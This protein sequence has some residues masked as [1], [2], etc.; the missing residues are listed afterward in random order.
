MD[1][2]NSNSKIAIV[3][4][5]I[6]GTYVLAYVLERIDTKERTLEKREIVE[7]MALAKQI[8][9]CNAQ[10][11][12]GVANIKGINCKLRQL[13]KYDIQGNLI[14]SEKKEVVVPTLILVGKVINGR[15]I[16]SYVLVH[17][18][19]RS[20]EIVLSRDTVFELARD[21]RI[22]NVKGQR[23]GMNKVLR[24]IN[25]FSL[26]SIKTYNQS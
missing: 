11:Y 14:I 4:R 10:M 18:K 17:V 9:N 5:V 15:E 26:N 23:D 25:N 22:L 20:K 21:G 24:G 12:N 6:E 13:P 16:Q 19:D 3:G 2:Y 8:Y 1:S 7:K